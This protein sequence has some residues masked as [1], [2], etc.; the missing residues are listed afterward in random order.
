MGTT[1]R[2]LLSWGFPTR[3][4]PLIILGP[5]LFWSLIIIYI[6]TKP[7]FLEIF[8]S[9]EKQLDEDQ[10]IKLYSKFLT[11]DPPH[12]P[13]IYFLKNKYQIDSTKIR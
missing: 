13:F 7:S 11:N 9:A 8:L 5:E 2:G 4:F 1:G 10:T 3:C 6:S 12:F